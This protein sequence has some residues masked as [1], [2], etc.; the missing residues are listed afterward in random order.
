MSLIDPGYRGARFYRCDLH[1][2]SQADTSHWR[3]PRMET[4]PAQMRAA[5][6]A[7]IRRCYEAGL[8]VIAVTDHNFASKS[9]IP[10]LRKAIEQLSGEFGYEIV[11]FPGFEFK[12]DVG[13]GVDV[14]AIFDPDLDLDSIDHLLTEC[15]VP[16]PRFVNNRP[17]KSTKRLP[18]ILEVVQRKDPKGAMKG[19]VILPHSQSDSGIFDK[20][21]IADWLQAEEFRNPDLYCIEIPKPPEEMSEGWQR[22]LGNGPDCD[23]QWR[24]SRPIACIMSS[25]AKA[26]TAGTPPG[27]YIGFRHTWMKMSRPS[28]E[29]LRQACLDPESRIRLGDQR[30]EEGYTYP[31]I[32]SLAVR[33]A[34]FLRDQEIVFSPNLTTVIGGRGTGKSTVVEYLRV[35][36]GQETA[37]RG[38]EPWKNFQKLRQTIRDATILS[39][40]LEKE[41]QSFSIESAGGKPPVV[42]EGPAIPDL[43]RFLPV[44]VLSQKEIYAIAEDRGARRRLVDDLVRRELDE[45]ARREE[46]LIREIKNLNEQ[47]ASLPELREREKALETERRDLEVRL[48]RLKA[49]EAPLARWK[50][51]LAEERFFRGLQEEA[52][53]IARSLREATEQAAFT[54]TTLGSELAEAPSHDLTRTMA[55]DADQLVAQLKQQI[56]TAILVF[57]RQVS[58]LL[59]QS[60]VHAWR[61]SLEAERAEFERLRKD[62]A[63]QGTDPDLYLTYQRG[64]RE[65]EVQ[66]TE[67]KKRIEGIEAL[68][69]RRDGREEPGGKHQPGLMDTLHLLW[70]QATEARQEA[71]SR[72][73]G[74]VPTTAS[75]QPFVQVSVEPFGDELAFL[76][77]FRQEIR[78]RRR[79][80][81]G[82]WDEFMQAVFGGARKGD[83]PTSPT[84]TLAV[85]TSRL[86]QRQRPEGCPWKVGD[87]RIDVILEWLT[88]GRL[89]DLQLW[90]TP[91]QVRIQLFRQDGSLVGD[92]EGPLSVGQRCTAVLG[93]VLAA[94]EAPV[95]IDQPEEDLDNEFIFVELVPLLRRVKERRQVIVVSHNANI[96]VNG[97]AELV[98]ALAIQ[99]GRGCQKEVDG[100]PAVGALDRWEVKRAVEDIMEGSEE[101]FRRRFEKYG[102]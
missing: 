41:G 38:E 58:A 71:A 69:E 96:P 102:F 68:K 83:T 56:E 30:P 19:L 36:T 95:V 14:L 75:G 90:R 65:K 37:L 82:D 25:D 80:S 22:L 61:Q 79:I 48:A 62:L 7:Y 3:G 13:K 40:R 74:A 77:R 73:T 6:E 57:E 100:K 88:D 33:G 93:L 53:A 9:F 32:R 49:L 50:G 98:V 91:D 54:V 60:D 35:A 78:D 70:R 52:A 42:T 67:L 86:R 87:R 66:L 43:A 27:H 97:D 64:L 101:A 11:L 24:R 99:S 8:E 23:P 39:V 89:A 59:S 20:E 94:D 21:K 12:A 45:V 76:E 16:P 92:L 47:I 1:M 28:I 2:H 84:S 4:I 10:L 26:M 85:W 31:R 34:A 44:R 29:A 81:E 63:E 17:N 55:D 72:L 18:D 51:R 46:D 5:A 15:G